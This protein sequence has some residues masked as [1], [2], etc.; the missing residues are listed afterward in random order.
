M[1]NRKAKIGLLALLPLLLMAPV[2]QRLLTDQN[3][4]AH[5]IGDKLKCMCGGCDQ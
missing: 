5:T 4:R 3:D 1:Q 2:A